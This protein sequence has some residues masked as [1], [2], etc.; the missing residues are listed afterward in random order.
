MTVS[1]ILVNG[2]LQIGQ[3]THPIGTNDPPQAADN[4]LFRWFATERL[5]GR[6]KL[7]WVQ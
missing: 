4:T 2:L 5:R 6:D 3:K 7:P 1:T